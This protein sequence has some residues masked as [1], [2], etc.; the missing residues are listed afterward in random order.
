MPKTLSVEEFD[1]RIKDRFPQE[2][3]QILSY[4]GTGNPFSIKCQGCGQTIT[5]S[6]A[7]N[8]LAK[9]KAY[10]CV[11]CHGLWKDREKKWDKIKEKYY[12]ED[13]GST[14]MTHKLYRFICKKCGA[15]RTG[16]MNNVFLHLLCRCEGQANNWT[17]AEL[18][19]TLNDR[20]EV[21]GSPLHITDKTKLKCKRCGM[22]WDVRLADVIYGEMSGC[23]NCHALDTQSVGARFVNDCLD[24]MGIEYERE[25]PVGKTG[26]RFDF[27]VPSQNIAIEY[28]GAQHYKFVK[29]YH[30]NNAGFK[31]HKER[32]KK[33]ALYCGQN[34]IKLL[35]IPYTWKPSHIKEFLLAELGSTTSA[36]AR[37]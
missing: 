14:Y 23:P 13:T 5:V 16:T 12:V 11:N 6:K 15:I 31:K 7:I 22:I 27:F 4:S 30:V 33:K 29:I 17:P 34:G 25:K 35:V 32:D 2:M 9:N 21:L 3:F 18:K 19:A 37:S 24:E 36:S 1:S 20:Y 10:G 28:N 26:L 8:F